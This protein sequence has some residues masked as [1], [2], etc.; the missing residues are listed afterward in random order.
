[1]RP[2][3]GIDL[4]RYFME[5]MIARPAESTIALA[6]LIFSGVFER[7]PNLKLCVVHGGGFAP[8][9]IGRMDTGYRQKPGLAG[10][11]ISKPPSDYL[12]RIYVDT[13]LHEPA[14]LR[15]VVDLMGGDRVMLGTD[16]PFEMGSLDP[17]E[18]IE[19]AELGPDATNAILGETARGLL[20]L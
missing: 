4:S 16:Y 17:V 8:Y 20:G 14:A 3:Q 6:G 7:F 18:F 5:N 15:Y 9:Q 2:L 1:M 13:V 19:S 10:K 11:H 12:R